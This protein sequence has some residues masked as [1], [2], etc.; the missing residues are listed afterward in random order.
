MQDTESQIVDLGFLTKCGRTRSYEKHYVTKAEFLRER[1]TKR[2]HK[3]SVE[4]MTIDCWFVRPARIGVP[5]QQPS[6]ADRS[7][8]QSYH[9]SAT[10]YLYWVRRKTRRKVLQKRGAYESTV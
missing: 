8:E 7:K 9:R 1:Y 3:R 4:K 5:S 10:E 2:S 6:R